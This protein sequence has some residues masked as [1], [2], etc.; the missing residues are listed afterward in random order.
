MFQSPCA[1]IAQGLFIWKKRV[2]TRL[3]RMRGFDILECVVGQKRFLPVFSRGKRPAAPPPDFN[4]KGKADEFHV[5]AQSRTAS[6]SVRH[7]LHPGQTAGKAFHGK[8]GGPRRA[9]SAASGSGHRRLPRSGP[10]EQLCRQRP[11]SRRSARQTR[12]LV[13]R[14]LRKPQAARKREPLSAEKATRTVRHW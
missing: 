3:P 10:R 13:P 7:A 11:L 8:S 14:A 4:R 2:L 9:G 6:G 12:R 1:E 5:S